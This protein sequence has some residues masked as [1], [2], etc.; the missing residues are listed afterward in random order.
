MFVIKKIDYNLAAEHSCCSPPAW[1]TSSQAQ[2]APPAQLLTRCQTTVDWNREQI[3]LNGQ[4]GGL[5][6]TRTVLMEDSRRVRPA[7]GCSRPVAQVL[8]EP[9]VVRVF[10]ARGQTAALS[11]CWRE[12]CKS[13]EMTVIAMQSTKDVAGSSRENQTICV[14]VAPLLPN[15]PMHCF[16]CSLLW[17]QCGL[18][19]LPLEELINIP[20]NPTTPKTSQHYKTVVLVS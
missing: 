14:I 2:A 10:T 4:P 5:A 19:V 11:Q 17:C 3:E 6:I 8:S 18:F 1:R 20:P 16:I 9:A 13:K 12:T 15:Y 7:S